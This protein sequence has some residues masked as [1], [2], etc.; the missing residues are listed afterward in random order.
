LSP[1]CGPDL[2]ES[3]SPPTKEFNVLWALLVLL[4]LLAI[5]GG[6]VV[7]KFLFFVLVAVAVIALVGLFTRR[8]V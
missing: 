1:P 8:T 5:V 2:A 4:L 6:V 7:T 3:A